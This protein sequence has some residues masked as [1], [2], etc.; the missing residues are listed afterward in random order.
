MARRGQ[1]AESPK[2]AAPPEQSGASE[3]DAEVSG[4]APAEQPGQDAEPGEPSEGQPKASERTIRSLLGVAQQLG[5]S[6]DDLRKLSEEFAALSEEE[7]T[8]QLSQ[9]RAHLKERQQAETKRTAREKARAEREARA[10]YKAKLAKVGKVLC[11]AKTTCLAGM[12]YYEGQEF[13][14]DADEA[15]RREKRGELEIL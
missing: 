5:A 1:E 11:R 3:A 10:E 9:A 7:C 13:T 2:P 8:E 14:L 6:D 12:A 4:Q 15:K